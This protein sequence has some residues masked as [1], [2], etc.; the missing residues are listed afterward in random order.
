VLRP[1]QRDFLYVERTRATL[2]NPG[3]LRYGIERG[4]LGEALRARLDRKIQADHRACSPIQE[5]RRQAMM[6]CEN[7]PI[8]VVGRWD[9]DIGNGHE[10]KPGYDRQLGAEMVSAIIALVRPANFRDK[11]KGLVRY[12][13]KPARA[14]SASGL[15][16]APSS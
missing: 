1:D 12:A 2:H 14:I 15:Q 11:G 8:E 6:L 7:E 16:I 3:R 10:L 9:V 13:P 5:A 4:V